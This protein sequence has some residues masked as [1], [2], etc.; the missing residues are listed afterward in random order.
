MN[1]SDFRKTIKYNLSLPL[2]IILLGSPR[3]LVFWGFIL[4][5]GLIKAQNY[6]IE[7]SAIYDKYGI[8]PS[9]TF[10][11]IEDNQGFIWFG[12]ID[13]L[14]RY[15]GFNYKIFRNDP[16]NPNSISNNTIR[17]MAIDREGILWIGT[18]GGGLNAFDPTTEIFQH[19][20]NSGKKTG[21]ISGNTVWSV[22][23]TK[24]G[25]IW[26]GVSGQGLDRLDRE[27][28]T[29]EHFSVLENG[30]KIQQE[31]SIRSLL[32]VEDG[33][34]W[35]GITTLGISALNPKNG[36]VKQIIHQ[37]HDQ[38]ALTNDQPF[39]MIM[40]H[41]G[42]IWIAT[43]G[44]G[45]NILNPATFQMDHIRYQPGTNSI[46][47]D[48]TYS[49]AQRIEKEYWFATE[50]G[51]SVYNAQTGQ[52]K[53]IQQGNSSESINENRVRKIFIDSKGIVWAGSESGVDRLV[54]QSNF[55]MYNNF[56]PSATGSSKSIVKAISSDENFLW[57]GLIDNGLVRLSLTDHSIKRYYNSNYAP[58]SLSSNNINA[59]LI[60]SEQTMWLSDWNSG[61]MKYNR[62]KDNFTLI[63]N[64]YYEQG[65]LPD[66]RVQRI[67]EG[68]KG[69]LWIS[70]EGGLSR[71]DIK[72][73]SFIN[74]THNPNDTNS[75]SSNSLQSQAIVFD[76]DSNL[77][78][79]SW[80]FGL[81]KMEFTNKERT[82]A[83]F[84]RFR[85]DPQNPNSLP[86]NNVISL[87]YDD[88]LLWIGT[89]GGG[90]SRYE[91]ET[92]KF[93]SY[94]TRDG[95]PNN[96]VFAIVKDKNGNL[97]LSTDFGISMFNPKTEEFQNYTA[98]D[99]LQGNHFFWGAAY[100]DKEGVIY[101][102][103]INGLNSFIPEEVKPD[104]SPAPA[105]L[106]DI[107]LFNE[108]VMQQRLDKSEN[109]VVFYYDENFVSFEFAALDYSVPT[110][111]QYRYKLEGFDKEWVNL[112][113]QNSSSYTNLQPGKYTFM[114][115]VSNSDGF[116]N[117]KVVTTQVI[118]VPP[119]WKTVVAQISFILLLLAAIFGGYRIRLKALQSQKK[120]LEEQVRLR[121]KEIEQKNHQL[122][123]QRDEL[124]TR[125]NKLH[126]TLSE[127]EDAQAALI[128][129]EKM[130]A[131]GILT[132]GVAHEI[133]N[134][135]NFISVSIENIKSTLSD[136]Q[137]LECHADSQ[138]LDELF[139]LIGH[140]ESGIER[141]IN[142][143]GGLKT[144]MNNTEESFEW[145]EPEVL[146]NE[147]VTFLAH[148]IPSS[149][150][151]HIQIESTPPIKARKHRLSQVLINIIDNALQAIEEG[152][153]SGIGC[154]EIVVKKSAFR[155]TDC[156]L[157]EIANSGPPIKDEIIN[158]LFDPF[159][160]TKAPNK[161]S[162]LGLYI[163]H[164]IVNE[165]N[166]YVDVKNKEGKVIF[167]IFVPIQTDL[168]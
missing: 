11:I 160:T 96:I 143:V 60:D 87:L 166:G 34:I 76:P 77:W 53:T 18:Q 64:A 79:G 66:N 29:F 132:A 25:T 47:S 17:A 129:S 14:Y 24:D 84:K 23:I 90:L 44:G 163:T 128:K 3:L 124:A 35:A 97:W 112:T 22:L 162:G 101:F 130:A 113:G 121:T 135:L 137:A 36:K 141:I 115:Q 136:F 144:L 7:I 9:A 99:G 67:I 52:F 109:K 120:L 150:D 105:V 149:I 158:Y 26:V 91:I 138:N 133:N 80:S 134:P 156:V 10:A 146:V 27:S 21:E 98:E 107:K 81:N 108:S 78:L 74:Y 42:N 72:K 63:S 12:T 127:L 122:N 50:Y 31:Q 119:W 103:G 51:I 94:T 104:T 73:N 49:I 8:P 106:I 111:N 16:N 152:N 131:L 93:T 167:S 54:L 56:I 116:W 117:P 70:T 139:E 82:E 41:D 157:F 151:L 147:S 114:L 69:I 140:A 95:L 48:L 61:L 85:H 154:I 59:I 148:K 57:I 55:K 142:I 164:S 161:G 145:V 86:N 65:R 100:K 6:P 46:I 40:G 153:S 39:D 2:K 20:Q 75:L 110:K 19:Y 5:F 33:T 89:F 15:D 123:E 83:N 102:G 159:F 68:E 43:Y 30:E 45:I 126:K 71:Y 168:G 13:G 165:H 4:F 125:N 28:G 118:I 37:Y 38:T 155:H 1:Y 58:N 32:E 92:E 62:E 88:S